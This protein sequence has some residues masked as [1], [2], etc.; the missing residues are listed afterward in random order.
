MYLFSKS[1]FDFI[2]FYLLQQ[3]S[4]GQLFKILIYVFLS[5][6]VLMQF[7]YNISL[8]ILM[9]TN[10]T[11]DQQ[12]QENF[13]NNFIYTIN[14][15]EKTANIIGFMYSKQTISIPRSI[16]HENQEYLITSLSL[17]TDVYRRSNI[18]WH[19]SQTTHNSSKCDRTWRRLF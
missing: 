19:V 16:N 6:Y 12:I 1:L 13:S 15:E 18:W 8:F 4:F 2:I 10:R 17:N 3:D 9:I 7:S 11:K 5:G 14:K